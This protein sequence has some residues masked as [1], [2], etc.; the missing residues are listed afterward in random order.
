[1]RL[2]SVAAI[3]ASLM[4]LAGCSAAQWQRANAAYEDAFVPIESI[5]RFDRWR[6]KVSPADLVRDGH[7]LSL[8]EIGRRYEVGAGLPKD[9]DCAGWW[10]SEALITWYDEP[11]SGYAGGHVTSLGTLRRQGLPQARVALKR[12]RAAG[13]VTLLDGAQARARCMPFVS[14]GQAS[15]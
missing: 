13:P 12:L 6:Q 14:A 9:R 4:T 7:P 2:V 10:Y 3:T 5:G 11:Q 8:V 15:R 1:M